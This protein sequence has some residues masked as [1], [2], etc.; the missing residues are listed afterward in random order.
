MK[1]NSKELIAMTI[2]TDKDNLLSK[3]C[4][5]TT[6]V[7]YVKGFSECNVWRLQKWLIFCHWLTHKKEYMA[8][9]VDQRGCENSELC[10]CDIYIFMYLYT[11]S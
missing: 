2:V 5:D 9:A 1:I 3:M 8:L 11:C 6:M 10:P 7:V 4:S